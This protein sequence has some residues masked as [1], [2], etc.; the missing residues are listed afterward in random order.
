M[1]RRWSLGSL[2]LALLLCLAASRA[3]AASY[4][5][6]ADS[7][8]AGRSHAIVLARAVASEGVRSLETEVETVTRFELVESVRG[9]VPASFA[10]AVPG[11][12]L[13]DGSGIWFDGVPRFAP[14]REYLLFLR[15]GADG[16]HSVT[17]LALGSFDVLVD[18]AGT[19]YATR[20]AFLSGGIRALAAPGMR[21]GAESVRDLD[22]FLRYLRALDRNPRTRDDA[23]DSGD[24]V[25]NPSTPLRPEGTK[26][27]GAL[28]V[29]IIDTAFMPHNPV[30]WNPATANVGFV[31]DDLTTLNQSGVAD[32]GLTEF[33]ASLATWNN[34]PTS[35]IAYTA[36]VVSLNV[37][38]HWDNV[39][40][41]GGT[42][43]PCSLGT[44]GL[45][46]PSYSSTTHTFKGDTYHPITGGVV[47]MRRWD[48]ADPYLSSAFQNGLTHEL[49]HTLGLNHP[50]QGQS[51]HDTT[52]NASG[53]VMI[54]ISAYDRPVGLGAD[55][56][57]AICWL[58]GAC[59][60]SGDVNGDGVTNVAD[61]FY[62]INY[63]FAGGP[64]PLY[65]GNVDAVGGVDVSDVFY[66]I[67][68]L[69]AG[70]P[71]PH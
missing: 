2:A 53:A 3:R 1:K 26:G 69:F 47:Y 59:L 28:W 31:D 23:P 57:E 17:E 43:I 6:I 34:D 16:R 68:F 67:N 12:E 30:R 35:T 42:G 62:L 54:S 56:R 52:N 65:G 14:G 44:L 5:L 64:A 8:L 61:V 49:G 4:V 71:P 33:T 39:S 27:I 60:T 55:D 10:V 48:C 46:G 15:R 13:P 18:G 40:Q 11:G 58:Y 21:A 36:A 24:Y 50:D 7:D 70:G 41:F 32:G 63:L 9:N 66:L 29:S 38:V 25:A 22:A 51:P 20:G 45:G 19:R 37:T